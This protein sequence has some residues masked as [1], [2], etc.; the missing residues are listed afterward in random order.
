MNTPS[1]CDTCKHLLYDCITEDDPASS[2][3]CAVDA[4]MGKV[5]CPLYA[6]DRHAT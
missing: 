1:P 6:K 4:P 3:W 2:A 5:E